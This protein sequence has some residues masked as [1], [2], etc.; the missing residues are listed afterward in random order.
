M[1]W[2]NNHL[3]CVLTKRYTLLFADHQL[4][5][6]IN[7]TTSGLEAYVSTVEPIDWVCMLDNFESL[8]KFF[9]TFHIILLFCIIGIIGKYKVLCFRTAF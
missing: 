5:L 9:S 6:Y 7:G 8:K 3:S 2:K 1:Y 4:S